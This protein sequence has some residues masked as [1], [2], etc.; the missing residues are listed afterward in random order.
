MFPSKVHQKV[1]AKK[2]ILEYTSN[3]ESITCNII[4]MLFIKLFSIKT[5]ES[6]AMLR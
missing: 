5:D 6:T 3:A 1:V 4:Y 2:T